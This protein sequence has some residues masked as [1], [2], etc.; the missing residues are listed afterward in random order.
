MVGAGR[1][2]SVRSAENL[3]LPLG[4]IKSIAEDYVLL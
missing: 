2:G 1:K 4:E 3:A